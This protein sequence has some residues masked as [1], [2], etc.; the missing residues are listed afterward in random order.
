MTNTNETEASVEQ[1]TG[2]VVAVADNLYRGKM[3]VLSLVLIIYCGGF[4]L[5]DGFIGWPNRNRTLDKL[6]KQRDAVIDPAEKSRLTKEMEKLGSRKTD[7]DIVLQKVIGFASVPLGAWVL[8]NSL[9]KSRGEIR[10]SGQ[11]IFLPG[12]S[13]IRFDAITT[14]DQRRW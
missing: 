13:P 6:D 1:K 11:T 8:F 3:L 12:R 4:F 5:Y 7:L 2:D 10:M 14:V 9:R